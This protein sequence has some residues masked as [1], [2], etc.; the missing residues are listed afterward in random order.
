[1]K[2]NAR[3]QVS[4]LAAALLLLGPVPLY[5]QAGT[6]PLI[7][8]LLWEV[9]GLNGEV[10]WQR[11]I[12]AVITDYGVYA[13]DI[14][15]PVIR[16]F[17]IE[18]DLLTEMGRRGRG[19]GEIIIPGS[20]ISDSLG[21]ITAFD[22]G[23]SRTVM[24]DQTGAHVQ[25]KRIPVPM[26]V[27]AVGLHPMV[28]GWTVVKT[29]FRGT[30]GGDQEQI[31]LAMSGNRI[32]TLAIIEGL[33]V[34]Y[35]SGDSQSRR[36]A[37]IYSGPTGG[38]ATVSDSTVVVVDGIRLRG[39]LITVRSGSL[40]RGPWQPLPG[41]TASVTGEDEELLQSLVDARF[42]TSSIPKRDFR[43]PEIWSAWT[44][45]EAGHGEEVW[46]R[47][48]GRETI[49]GRFERWMRWDVRSDE[50]TWIELP[51]GVRALH[52]SEHHIVAVRTDDLGVEA[53]QLYQVTN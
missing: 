33:S 44:K 45:V 28:D 36:S 40:V 38:F 50:T 42:A 6:D 26:E 13:L 46:L 49:S 11:L 21:R 29:G 31:G 16:R 9:G 17:S 22:W 20:I 23:Q 32:D 52:F 41:S 43:Y 4:I 35:I 15:I 53:L 25:T 1:M 14:Q 30:D 47:Q 19:P 51:P 7:P 3:T 2:P 39:R 18:G 12:D 37:T 27:A 34:T 48:G 10:I 24:F 5:G 8:R